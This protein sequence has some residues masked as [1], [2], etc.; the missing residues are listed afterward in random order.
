MRDQGSQRFTNQVG[1]MGLHGL[2]R[3]KAKK[4][5]TNAALAFV[6]ELSLKKGLLRQCMR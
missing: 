4:E 6:A 1:C 3:S 2:S 5:S